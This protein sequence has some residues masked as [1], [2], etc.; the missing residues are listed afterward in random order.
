[1]FSV[2]LVAKLLKERR[3]I[4]FFSAYPTAKQELRKMINKDE[5]GRAIIIDSGR[6]DA[7]LKIISEINDL[8]KRI[9]IIK[10]IDSYSKKIFTAMKKLRFVVY[11]GDIDKCL[12]ADE[13]IGL[14]FATKILFSRPKIDIK[15]NVPVLKKYQGY[16]HSKS[17]EGIISLDVAAVKPN[18]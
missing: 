9:V 3:K 4:V 18:K 1:M 13:L 10:N 5:G 7:F 17:R 8:Q 15:V 11:S 16:F 12:F 6:E 2:C 14:E